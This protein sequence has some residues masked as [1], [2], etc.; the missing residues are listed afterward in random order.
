M[1]PLPRTPSHLPPTSL[2]PPPQERAHD[3]YPHRIHRKPA[4]DRRLLR[5]GG[6]AELKDSFAKAETEELARW[7]EQQ[8][9]TMPVS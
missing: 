9:E 1:W 2:P 5:H 3:N 4:D 8:I 7:A 6:S